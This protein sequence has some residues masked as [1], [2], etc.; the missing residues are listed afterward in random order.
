MYEESTDLM[1]ESMNVENEQRSL[2]EANHIQGKN[3]L[4]NGSSLPTTPNLEL[5]N[6]QFNGSQLQN[7]FYSNQMLPLNSP[8]NTNKLKQKNINTNKPHKCHI[9]SKSFVSY[10]KLTSFRI[11]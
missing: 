3:Q 8:E 6:S 2:S 11:F 1:S 4:S 5:N 9:C 10:F 7:Q